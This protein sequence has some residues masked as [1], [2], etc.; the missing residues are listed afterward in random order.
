MAAIMVSD[1]QRIEELR[2]QIRHHDRL[3]YVEARPGISD[4]QYDRLMQE[5]R[6]LEAKHPEWITPDSPTQRVAGSPL[7]E[8]RSAHHLTPML[9][10]DNTYSQ[11]E[12]MEFDRR[13]QR[14]LGHD[15]YHYLVDPKIDGVAVSLLYQKGALM[16]AATRGDGVTGDDITVNAR[17]IRAVPLRLSGKDV[18]DTL[19]VRGEIYWPR[20]EFNAFNARRAGEG[21]EV[22]A[23]AR[24]GAAGTL[25]QL[26]PR[27]VAQR[28]LAFLAHGVGTMSPRVA[29]RAGE[30]MRQ[31]ARWGIPTNPHAR[32]CGNVQEAMQAVQDWLG[33]R[34]EADFETD[35]MV[36]KM[37]ELDLREQLGQTSRYPRW[38][39]AY[40]YEAQQAQTV[41]RSVDFQVGRLGTITPVA[42]FD[43]VQLAGTTVSNASLHNFD[44]IDRLDARVGDTVLVE[45]AGEII[46][47]VVQ[48]LHAHRP[49][50]A[51]P[52]VPPGQ[53]PACQSPARR[54]E[55][56]VYLRCVNP[57][58]PAQIRERLRFYAARGQMDIETLGPAI[59]DQLV[60]KRLV[61]HFAD[62]YALRKG[63]LVELE[64]MGE[65]SAQ[66]LLDGIEQSKSR[67]LMRVLAGLG[68][69]HVGG[70]AAQI[71]AEHFGDI[72]RLAAA[73]QEE[74]TGIREIG[75]VIARGVHEFFHGQA[76]RETIRR[77]KDAGVKMAADR[78]AREGEAQPLAGKTVVITG[79]LPTLS[80]AQ[81]EQA[82]KDAGGR[83]ASSVSKN[84]DFVVVGADPG[85]KGDKARALGAEM[86]DEAEFLRRLERK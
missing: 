11:Q 7:E 55:G 9:S 51:Q 52:I 20:K 32:I 21:L 67:G 48:V 81:A 12:V 68:I 85:S 73:G 59:I 86:I 36:I 16:L 58:C 41:L 56:G 57:E 26:D 66:N 22:F 10:I 77:L 78:P 80:R 14:A 64:R 28:K 72:D 44:Q 75:P 76:G 53:C 74:L 27:V 42:H 15:R 54:D 71:L 69:R 39:I 29:G 31:L 38:C 2:A 47:R 79:T 84:T 4:R 61:R 23:N 40:K 6:Q 65:K 24:N 45:K 70:R 34:T 50:E 3:Y 43:P 83:A 13:V 1:A 60:D 5:L 63:D 25:K 18:P 33:Q 30:V 49:R 46:P 17:T 37:D 82:V 19:E 8:F 35:G 62:L